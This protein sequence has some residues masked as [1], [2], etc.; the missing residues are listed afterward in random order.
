MER[1]VIDCSILPPDAV[2]C[3]MD[4][5]SQVRLNEK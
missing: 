2:R 4:C 3:G 1:R 5:L